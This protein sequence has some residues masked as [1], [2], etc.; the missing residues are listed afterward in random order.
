MFGAGRRPAERGGLV[1]ARP[2]AAQKLAGRNNGVCA[3]RDGVV[4]AGSSGGFRTTC[5]R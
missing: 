2:V 3:G 1:M 4:I 5:G